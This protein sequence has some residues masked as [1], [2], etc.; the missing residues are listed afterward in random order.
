MLLIPGKHSRSRK[1]IKQQVDAIR[2]VW[3][4]ARPFL[5]RRLDMFFHCWFDMCLTLTCGARGAVVVGDDC[6]TAGALPLTYGVERAVVP[7]CLVV[8]ACCLAHG[9]LVCCSDS[10]LI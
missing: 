5:E 7:C 8:F 4:K 2:L 1:I 3:S 9:T 10:G 6:G